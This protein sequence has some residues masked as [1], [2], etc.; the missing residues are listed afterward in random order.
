MWDGIYSKLKPI[1][2]S[3]E[4][5][6]IQNNSYKIKTICEKSCLSRKENLYY[7]IISYIDLNNNKF[8][9]TISEEKEFQ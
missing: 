6:N 9:N 5:L 1:K 3:L 8:Y 2:C 4:N 7:D